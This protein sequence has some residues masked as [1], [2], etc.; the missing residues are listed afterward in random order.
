LIQFSL[1]PHNIKAVFRINI[2]DVF[3][4][5]FTLTLLAIV[6][7]EFFRVEPALALSRS[8]LADTDLQR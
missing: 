7:S 8:W 3:Q 5:H 4:G 2:S 1:K 6:T